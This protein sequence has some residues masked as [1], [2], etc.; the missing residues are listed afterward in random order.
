MEAA[1]P[2]ALTPLA[3]GVLELLLERPVHPYEMHQIIRDRHMDHVIKLRAGSLYH[4]VER[5]HRLQLIEPVETAR[6]GRRPE[7]TVYAITDRGRDM[8]A[9][10]LRD[11]IQRPEKEYP[12][13]GA[14]TEMLH[15]LDPV[16]AATLLE[17]R[18]VA[19]EAIVAAHDQV[20]ASLGK[21]GLERAVLLEIEYTQA[22][23]RAELAWIRGIVEDIRGGALTWSA[24]PAAFPKENP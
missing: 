2:G 5:L 13:F 7:R 21:T 15:T 24:S 14:A 22:L 20:I 12:V 17:R 23:H 6:A 10:R 11:L 16:E 18:I 1:Q 8:F 19:L 9:A 3:L 4:T